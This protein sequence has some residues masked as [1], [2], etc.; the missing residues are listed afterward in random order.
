MTMTAGWEGI[1]DEGEEIV[2][3]GRPDGRIVF[4]VTNLMGFVFGLIFAGFALFWMIMASN[5]GGFFWMFG[6]IHFFVG[7]GIAFGAIY[8]NA[9]LRR[10]SWYTLTD[11]RAFVASDLPIIGRRLKSYPI[12]EDTVLEFDGA[13][14]ATI[15]F[16]SEFKRT[17]NGTR[18]VR[19][20]FERIGDGREVYRKFREVQERAA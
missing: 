6:L 14:P 17:K 12:D 20:G 16:A 2:W 8:W 4:R 10:N 11:R 3:Q 13:D 1:L 9:F 15:Y 18:E 5:A 7:V 19:I